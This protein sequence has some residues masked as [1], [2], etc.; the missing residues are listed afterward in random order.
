MPGPLRPTRLSRTSN[1]Q[2]H[3]CDERCRQHVCTPLGNATIRQIH[4]IL[5][6]AFKRAV[7]WRWVSLNPM[8]QAEPPAPKPNP[9]P[10][11]ANEA[12]AIRN[13][14]WNDPD[15]GTFVWLAMTTGARRGELCALR[16][17]QVNLDTGVLEVARSIAQDSSRPGRRPPRRTR[18]VASLWTPRPSPSFGSTRIGVLCGL[19]YLASTWPIVPTSSHSIQATV[20]IFGRTR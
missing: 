8:A 13:D 9:R 14:A 3:E 1:V 4:F 18:S 20:R 7:R 16:W 10:P 2:D 12:A 15:W 17:S 6:G 11:S 5:S 19:T